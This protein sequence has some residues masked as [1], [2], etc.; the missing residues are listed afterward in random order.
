MNEE[1]SWTQEHEQHVQAYA[2]STREPLDTAAAFAR[3]ERSRASAPTQATDARTRYGLLVAIALPLAAAALLWLASGSDAALA[4]TETVE[5][6]SPDLMNATEDAFEAVAKEPTVRSRRVPAAVAPPNIPQP[7]VVEPEKPL[8]SATEQSL[9]MPASKNATRPTKRRRPK[10]TAPAPSPVPASALAEELAAVASMRSALRRG[11]YEAVLE[12][13]AEHQR[14]FASPSLA[15]ERDFLR[16]EALCGLDDEVAL[17]AAKR[18]FATT[19]ASH[20]L[21][22]RARSVCK[23]TPPTLQTDAR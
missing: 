16:L 4:E 19:H 14:R 10:Q 11:A 5:V 8:E 21:T 22:A 15:A 2:R 7:S 23:K 6:L 17:E 3:F 12:R 20:H 1:V 9:P 13:V 18:A